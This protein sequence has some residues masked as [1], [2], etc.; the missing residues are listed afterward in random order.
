MAKGQT[1]QLEDMRTAIPAPQ[2]TRSFGSEALSVRYS[3]SPAALEKA[4]CMRCDSAV[5]SVHSQSMMRSCGMSL[6]IK[7]GKRC[8]HFL[9][10]FFP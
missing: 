9:R 8:V 3:S 4:F 5:E 10:S 6:L 1:L 2:H 7:I